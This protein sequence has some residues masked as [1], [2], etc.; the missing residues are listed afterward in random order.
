MLHD[1]LIELGNQASLCQDKANARGVLRESFDLVR[2][3]SDHNADPI[4]VA[5]WLSTLIK[6]ILSSSALHSEARLT[7]AFGRCE[8]LPSSPLLFVDAEPEILDFFNEVGYKA[9]NI[10]ISDPSRIETII[11]RA[12]LG[13]P[14]TTE[15]GH[16]LAQYAVEHRPPALQVHDGLPS[17]ESD[18]NIHEDLIVPVVALSRWAAIDSGVV[19]SNTMKRLNEQTSLLAAETDSLR[20]AW[21]TGMRLQLSNWSNKVHVEIYEDMSQ[22]DRAQFGA[23]CRSVADT[24]R[25]VAQRLGY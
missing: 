17:K 22:I 3:A 19:C 16:R 14:L 25:A 2:N 20:D 12:D 6:D 24:I 15:E 11:A 10:D 8:G 4:E 21:I 18:V 13:E 1:S 9:R 7:G 5:A 23:S